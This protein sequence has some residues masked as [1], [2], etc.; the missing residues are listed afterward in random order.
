MSSLYI[1]GNGFDSAHG[2]K[3]SYW[4]FRSYL[5]KY[6]EAFLVELEK[7]YGFQPLDP[8]DWRTERNW[9]IIQERR[10]AELQA[11]LWRCFEADLGHADET[12]MLGFS[13]SIIEDLDLESGPVGI[14]DT[15]D[16]YWEEQ[17]QFIKEL[18]NYVLMWVK[19]IRINKAVVKRTEM[20]RNFDDYF[21][22][23][24]YTNVLERIY[25]IPSQ[26]ILHIHGGLS[27]YCDT[28]PVMGH[29]NLEVIR[30]YQDL[31]EQAD[32]EFD[33]GSKSIYN[34]IIKYYRR[35][36]K[37]V[38]RIRQQNDRFFGQ[39]GSVDTVEIIGHS[40]GAVDMPYFQTVK[41]SISENSVWKVYYYNPDDEPAFRAAI[42]DLGV[43][44][45]HIQTM[46]TSAFWNSP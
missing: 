34:A 6:A 24:N 15:M 9:D 18:Q 22:T 37:D 7:M 11:K 36:F 30:H 39:L 40:L 45:I 44:E 35:T 12:E 43:P 38:N 1:I 27:P 10:T 19:Q 14:E 3:T 28:L 25:K 8:Y 13:Q 17:Y 33:E 16:Q 23:F 31:V 21:L 32:E 4:H 26:Q 42:A 2:L 20:Y 41:E 46:P 5:E 29:G